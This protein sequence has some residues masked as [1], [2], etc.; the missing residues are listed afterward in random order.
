MQNVSHAG[1]KVEA[2]GSGAVKTPRRETQPREHNQAAMSKK[3]I[4]RRKTRHAT[5]HKLIWFITAL[6]VVLAALI[7]LGTLLL[8][9]WVR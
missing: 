7:M 9:D 2:S 8:I 1:T 5:D 4:K 3:R 6:F